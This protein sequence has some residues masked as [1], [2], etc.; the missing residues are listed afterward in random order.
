MLA[1]PQELEAKLLANPIADRL[2]HHAIADLV[3][4]AVH[5]VMVVGNFSAVGPGVLLECRPGI[6]VWDRQQLKLFDQ[7]ATPPIAFSRIS[8]T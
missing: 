8:R 2:S 1:Q 6:Y 4:V 7:E 5:R 3:R